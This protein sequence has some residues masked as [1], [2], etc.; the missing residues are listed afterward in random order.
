MLAPCQLKRE[1]TLI[2]AGRNKLYPSI[3]LLLLLRLRYTF[4]QIV[5]EQSMQPSI[6]LFKDTIDDI[7]RSVS[8]PTVGSLGLI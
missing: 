7:T 1:R 4:L 3:R 6:L 8:A 5:C 2:K